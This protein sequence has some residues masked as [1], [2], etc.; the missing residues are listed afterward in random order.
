MTA[1]LP[2]NWVTQGFAMVDGRVLF[3]GKFHKTEA[4][5]T[6]Y[7]WLPLSSLRDWSSALENITMLLGLLSCYW[8][9]CKQ[10]NKVTRNYPGKKAFP[11]LLTEI[12]EQEK[13][14]QNISW[15]HQKQLNL[16]VKDKN[17]RSLKS[18]NG[19]ED[20]VMTSPSSQY[21]MN[22]DSCFSLM[23]L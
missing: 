22:L 1:Q 12:F 5:N 14:S 17:F 19:S 7:S 18:G 20:Q 21:Q 9:C 23:N 16:A 8:S 3:S 2:F 11:T 6:L 13:S 4:A 15:R 10:F